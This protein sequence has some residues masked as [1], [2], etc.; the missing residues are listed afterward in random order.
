MT[1]DLVIP[2]YNEERRIART[3]RAYSHALADDDVRFHVA[4]DGCRDAT[5]DIVRDH[6]AVDP[7]VDLFDFPKLGKG[8]VLMEAFRRCDGD[9]IG[10]V[11]ADCATPPSELALLAEAAAHSDG[12]IATRRHPSSITPGARPL[13]RR[14]A[15]AGFASGVRRLFGLGYSD[16]QCGAKVLCRALIDDALPLLSSR[17][18]LFDVD[19]LVIADRLG[20]QIT[21][22]PTVWVD[23]AEST[24]SAGADSRRMLASAVRLWVHHRTLPID[25]GP[26]PRP[27]DHPRTTDD[28]EH[29]GRRLAA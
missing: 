2:A 4:L 29:P 19:L 26:A 1:L 22:V 17:D 7:R 24:L 16:T 25:R 10:F 12:A 28:I 15:S 6:A 27:V 18:F 23:Q 8:G 14:V 5:A 21:E 11:D 9:L 13:A 3:L 20:Y